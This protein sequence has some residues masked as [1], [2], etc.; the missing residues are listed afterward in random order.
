MNQ[1]KP[2]VIKPFRYQHDVL[3]SLVHFDTLTLLYFYDY[4]GTSDKLAHMIK[5]MR[6]TE[7]ERF[8]SAMTAVP[9]ESHIWNLFPDGI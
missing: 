4:V 3:C 9:P 5:D 7:P 6:D 8:S 2:H 1:K